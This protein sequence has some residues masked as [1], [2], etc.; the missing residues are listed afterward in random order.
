MRKIFQACAHIYW[1]SISNLNFYLNVPKVRWRYSLLTLWLVVVTGVLVHG[2]WFSLFVWP[3]LLTQSNQLV[4]VIDREYPADLMLEIKD[5][6]LVASGLEASTASAALDDSV[7]T[8]SA[9]PQASVSAMPLGFSRFGSL[10]P[11]FD[12]SIWLDPSGKQANPR[13]LISVLSDSLWYSSDG[14]LLSIF[15]FADLPEEFEYRLDADQVATFVD[16]YQTS[17]DRLA[18]FVPLALVVSELLLWPLGVLF[19]TLIRTPILWAA[20]LLIRRNLGFKVVFQMGLH[21]SMFTHTIAIISRM[22]FRDWQIVDLSTIGFYLLV[23]GIAYTY[24]KVKLIKL[25]SDLSLAI[26]SAPRFLIS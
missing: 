5:Q 22:L 26:V 3:E 20:L 11:T 25:W 13:A 4:E 9:I 16:E 6:K 19:I 2:L 1:Q 8:V 21:V 23:I 14:E 10:P 15:S 12:Y 18:W 17:Q 7:A 24:S